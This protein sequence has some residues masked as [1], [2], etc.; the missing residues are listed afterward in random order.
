MRKSSLIKNVVL[1]AVAI[2]FVL[3]ACE[4]SETSEPVIIGSSKTIQGNITKDTTWSA[5]DTIMLSGFVYVKGA[6]LTIEAGTLIKGVPGSKA[7]LII[8]RGSKIMAIGTPSK[9]IV[10]TSGKPAGQRGYGDWGGIVLCGNASTNKHDV[11]TGIGIAEGG[12]GSQYGGTN[13][14][15]NSGTMQ[16]VR[17]EFSG[18]PLT[19]TANSEL[20]GLTLYGVGSGTTIDHIQVSYCGDD[21]YEYFGGTVNCKYL[22]AF[23]GWDDEFDTDNGYR[24]KLQFILSLRD[25]RAADQ[26]GSNGF[27]SD[28]DADGSSLTPNTHPIFSNV[29]FFGPLNGTETTTSI[30]TKYE[31]AMQIR[32]GSTLC[33]YN[34]IF[35][36]YPKAGLYLDGAKGNTPA[37]AEDNTLQ[38]E[39]CIMAGMAVNYKVA[40]GTPATPYTVEQVQAYFESASRNNSVL[41]TAADLKITGPFSL[42]APNFLP[43]SGSPALTGAAFTNSNLSDAFFDKTATY[44]GAFGTTDWTQSWCNWDPQ[45]T[46]Y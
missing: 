36:G 30:D 38:I 7:T 44:K 41:T 31:H 9:P 34:S 46:K 4:K 19:S 2:V 3:Q 20:N 21:S 26:S 27:E 43:A 8:E 32:R 10:F 33:V 37:K 11:S 15:D 12:I 1:I 13:D 23:R 39:N 28:N 22:V 5:K 29:S 42:T 40:S 24:G 25:P 6:T 17:I 14:A 18:I 35:V 16:Y 45:N